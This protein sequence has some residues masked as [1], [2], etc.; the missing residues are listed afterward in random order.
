MRTSH[1]QLLEKGCQHVG[2]DYKNKVLSGKEYI[3]GEKV[4]IIEI[5]F[6]FCLLA[7]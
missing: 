3:T 1:S 4:K 2:K 6:L 7:G 5:L